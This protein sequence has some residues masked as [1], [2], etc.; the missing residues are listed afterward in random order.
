MILKN[1]HIIFIYRD[2]QKYLNKNNIMFVIEEYQKLD[3]LVQL[4]MPFIIP[5]FFLHS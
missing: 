5:N 2:L 3:F 4:L 1:I